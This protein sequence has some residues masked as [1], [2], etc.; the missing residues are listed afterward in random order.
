[1][2]AGNKVTWQVRAPHKGAI[3]LDNSVLYFS[4]KKDG[5]AAPC[6]RRTSFFTGGVYGSVEGK[7][8]LG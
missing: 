3:F 8:N 5:A 4:I 6:G 1:M 7:Q 2:I